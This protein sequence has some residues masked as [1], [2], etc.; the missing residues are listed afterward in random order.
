MPSKGG[1]RVSFTNPYTKPLHDVKLRAVLTVGR[2]KESQSRHI[3]VS[4]NLN[5]PDDDAPTDL[6]AEGTCTLTSMLCYFLGLCLPHI[7]H[8]MSGSSAFVGTEIYGISISFV[9]RKL[10]ILFNA[11]KNMHRVFSSI[12]VRMQG[13]AER[14]NEGAYC[15]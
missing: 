15:K 8:S 14:P 1:L 6:L 13:I 7:A 3:T 2:W 12:V 5:Q 9:C 10:S 11:E 4:P